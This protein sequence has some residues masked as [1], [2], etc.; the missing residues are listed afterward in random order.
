VG[1]NDII[2][3]PFGFSKQEYG[4]SPLSTIYHFRPTIEHYFSP[5]FSLRGMYAWSREN[6][7]DSSNYNLN[8]TTNRYEIA[9][10]FY[11][12]N[13]RHIVSLNFGYEMS[14]ADARSFTYTAPYAAI[15]YYTRFPSKT[16][17][18][19]RYQLGERNYKAAPVLYNDER[20]DRRQSWS[21]VLSQEFLKNYFTSFAFNYIDNH[22][23]DELYSFTKET[24]T[25][26]VG[27]YF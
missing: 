18:F 3:L 25:L 4:S 19:L 17:F 2:K 21:F 22:S 1:P 14:F 9:P 7:M 24:Y 10:N 26:S 15:S 20:V 5:N 12:M 11:F 13:R 16:D 6:F 23:N 8:N 27:F